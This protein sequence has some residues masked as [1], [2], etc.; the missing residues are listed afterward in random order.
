MQKLLRDKV[1]AGEIGMTVGQGFRKWTSE[2]ADDARR[3]LN[4]HLVQIAKS[5]GK[6][7]KKV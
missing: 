4:E 3:T 1:A 6:S 7:T 2:E 5:R